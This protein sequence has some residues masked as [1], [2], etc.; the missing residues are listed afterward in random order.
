MTIPPPPN[1]PRC[2]ERLAWRGPYAAVGMLYGLSIERL[3]YVCGRCAPAVR[4]ILEQRSA[5]DE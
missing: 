4:R 5:S 1:C 3:F 2:G